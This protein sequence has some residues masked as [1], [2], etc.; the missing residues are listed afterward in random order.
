MHTITMERDQVF[1]Q[2]GNMAKGC[3]LV[4]DVDAAQFAILAG[5]GE[6]KMQPFTCTG[7]LGDSQD[8][9]GKRIVIVRPGRYGDLILLTPVLREIKRRWPRCELGVACLA[10]Y[11]Q[12][13]MGA[14]YIDF[15]HPYP[16]PIEQTEDVVLLQLEILTAMQ[17]SAQVN[18][19]TDLFA[20]RLG[21]APNLIEDKS[22]DFFLSEDERD[23]AAEH[24]PRPKGLKRIGVHVCASDPV[25]DYPEKSMMVILQLLH[26]AG[27]DLVMLGLPNQLSGPSIKRARNVAADNLSFRQSAAVVS[28]CDLLIGPD[29]SLLHVAA[30]LR[31]QALGLYGSFAA[32]LR[33]RYHPK[34]FVIES[35]RGC[36]IAPCFFA[37]HGKGRW[38]VDGPCQKT[39][40]CEAMASI[41]PQEVLHRVQKLIGPSAAD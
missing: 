10:H 31:Q 16:L 40:R 37:Q 3:Y 39:H 4:E 32:D 15:F 38:P 11:Q 23:W 36:D 24:Y 28:T 13:L 33:T 2:G 21:I 35:K 8:F 1:A 12:A 25:R 14:P 22:P 19:I 27:Y 6:V 18:H 26:K 5:G 20:S 30:G 9:N 41:L 34:T 29:S 7:S 17:D